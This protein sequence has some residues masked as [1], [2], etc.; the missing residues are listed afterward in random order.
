MK[1]KKKKPSTTNK[2]GHEREIFLKEREIKESKRQRKLAKY[3]ASQQQ[4]QHRVPIQKKTRKEKK[5]EK[6]EALKVFKPEKMVR[7]DSPV[8]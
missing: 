1:S 6:K 2:A 7:I 3:L 4:S 8:I 5:R